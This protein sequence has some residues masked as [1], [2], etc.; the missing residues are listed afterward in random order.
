MDS[1]E[2]LAKLLKEN[3][4][5]KE[6][7]KKLGEVP[8][9][10]AE[11]ELRKFEKEFGIELR[12]EDFAGRELNDGQLKNV[13]GGAGGGGM[14]AADVIGIVFDVYGFIDRPEDTRRGTKRGSKRFN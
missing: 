11:K 3:E 14:S 9:E 12:E 10:D 2:A 7:F 5:A 4:N 8:E 6:K 13:S 1:K